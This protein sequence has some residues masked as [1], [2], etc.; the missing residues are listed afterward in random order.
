[1]KFQKLSDKEWLTAQLQ[2]KSM[3]DLAK[4]IG[5]SYG[6]VVHSVRKFAIKAPFKR[7]GP[8]PGTNMRQIAT[9]AYRKKYPNGRFGALASHWK[10]GIRRIGKHRAYVGRY[11]P[12]NPNCTSEGYVLEHRLI[13]EEH[14]GRFLK[15]EEVVHHK[16]GIKHDNRIKNLELIADRGTHT[17]EH[18]ERSHITELATIETERLRQLLLDNGINPDLP[19][20]K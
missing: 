6:G 14:L 3:R 2:T 7:S 16:N 5:C 13:M 10:G 18:F 15:P 11:A 1:M 9:A 4:E 19:V 12:D 8:K 17:R 20:D